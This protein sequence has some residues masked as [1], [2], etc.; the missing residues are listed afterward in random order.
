MTEATEGKTS[1][2]VNA[3][4]YGT[5]FTVCSQ[6]AGLY[7]ALMARFFS[8]KLLVTH[9]FTLS[10]AAMEVEIDGTLV[11]QQRRDLEVL[12]TQKAATLA[13]DSMAGDSAAVG[14]RPE[15]SVTQGG[16]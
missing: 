15:R 10:Q 4:V 12:L 7:A 8:A 11:S 6:N 16:G 2:P 5:D 14:W 1:L 9:A 3:V 13:S